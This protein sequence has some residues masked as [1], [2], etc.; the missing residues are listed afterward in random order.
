M[1]EHMSEGA[2]PIE[3]LS[4]PL[5]DQSAADADQNSHVVHRQAI[6]D[7][8]HPTGQLGRQIVNV[9]SIRSAGDVHQLGLHA[10]L[11]DD[12]VSLLHD[13]ACRV[14]RIGGE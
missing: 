13:G 11:R 5:A 14:V 3:A 6:L 10:E 1:A 4:Q 2:F 12:R 8:P 9:Q 7:E